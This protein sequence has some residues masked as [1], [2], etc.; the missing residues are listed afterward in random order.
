MIVVCDVL[1]IVYGSVNSVI[2]VIVDLINNIVVNFNGNDLIVL[3]N[4]D[5]LVYDV[6]GS[7]GGV[8][9]VKDNMFVRIIFILSVIY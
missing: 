3:F 6:V 1:V 9:F 5:G 8:D 2:L 4:S 7:M